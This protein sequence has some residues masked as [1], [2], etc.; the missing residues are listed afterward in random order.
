MRN[1]KSSKG[2]TLIELMI[3]VAII[4]IL[5]AVAVPAY[6]EYILHANRT[7]AHEALEAMAQA[8]ERYSL[9]N[10]SVYAAQA[11]IASVG[12]ANTTKGYYTLKINS[13][14]VTGF[15]ITATAVTTGPQNNDTGC[16]ALTITEALT[17]TPTACW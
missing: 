14:S 5:S 3:T 9:A 4:G 16:T 15:N 12:G 6:K 17:K 2:L 7:D 10:G 11:K 13:A 8:Q 1:I